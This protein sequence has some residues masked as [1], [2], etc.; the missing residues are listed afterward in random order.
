MTTET[1]FIMDTSQIKFGFGATHEVGH[2]M[3]ALG[4]KRVMVLTDPN[5]SNSE[6]VSITLTALSNVGIDAI[7]FDQVRVTQTFY[8]LTFLIIFA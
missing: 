5:L 7:L 8:N 4:G 2:D 1:A 3:Y 6:P